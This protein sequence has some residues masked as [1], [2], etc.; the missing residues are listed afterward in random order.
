MEINN[1]R[2]LVNNFKEC[3][4]FYKNQLEL[5]VSYGDIEGPYASF[6]TG[7]LSQLALF[8]SEMMAATVGTTELANAENVRDRFVIVIEVDNVDKMFEKLSGKK[9]LLY[10]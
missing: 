2:L 9:K 1:I 3:F 6:Q 10:K 8:K 5:K 4:E 7:D